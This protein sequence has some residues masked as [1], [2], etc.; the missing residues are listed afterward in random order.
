MPSASFLLILAAAVCGSRLAQFY[1]GPSCGSTQLFQSFYCVFLSCVF[2]LA[3]FF[4]CP[5]LLF[6]VSHCFLYLINKTRA[7]NLCFA[8]SHC[9]N[10]NYRGSICSGI[11]FEYTVHSND[12]LCHQLSGLCEPAP[13]SISL[14][15]PDAGDLGGHE[16]HSFLLY[17]GVDLPLC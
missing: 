15:M 6:Y 8:Q 9:C 10:C 1:F 3:A 13:C 4:C 11:C 12:H 17:V 5:E 7:H 14:P 16:H 2:V